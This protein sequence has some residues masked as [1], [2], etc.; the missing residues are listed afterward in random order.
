MEEAA[1][2]RQRR[3]T[4]IFF[5]R[6]A[7]LDVQQLN[8]MTMLCYG[9]FVVGEVMLLLA[10][11]PSGRSPLDPRLLQLNFENGSERLFTVRPEIRHKLYLL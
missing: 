10:R 7:G 4:I 8:A 11:L 2:E 6:I 9:L 1:K 3:R 5:L